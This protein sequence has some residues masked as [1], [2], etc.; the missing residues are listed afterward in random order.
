[1][2][3]GLSKVFKLDYICIRCTNRVLMA[4][5]IKLSMEGAFVQPPRKLEENMVKMSIFTFLSHPKLSPETGLAD[6]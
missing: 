3:S 5:Y 4:M 6:A 2:T 1:M